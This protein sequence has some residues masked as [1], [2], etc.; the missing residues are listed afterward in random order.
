MDY[1]AYRKDPTTFLIYIYHLLISYSHS[2]N[3]LVAAP[4]GIWFPKDEASY[5]RMAGSGKFIH[6]NRFQAEIYCYL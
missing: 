2:I 1:L 6:C 3:I 4:Y 5:I